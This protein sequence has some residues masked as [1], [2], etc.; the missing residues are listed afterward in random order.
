ME[1]ML[2]REVNS[3]FGLLINTAGVGP[4][5]IETHGRGVVIVTF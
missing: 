2:A 1:T 3:A 4:M 5:L